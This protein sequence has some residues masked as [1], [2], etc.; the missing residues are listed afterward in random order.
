MAEKLTRY[1]MGAIQKLHD[2][3]HY[4]CVSRD[5]LT[6]Q[7]ARLN[8]PMHVSRFDLAQRIKEIEREQFN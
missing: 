8:L 3:A 6:Q 7:L 1:E 2:N 4:M 5:Y